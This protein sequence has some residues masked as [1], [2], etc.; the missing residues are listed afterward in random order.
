MARTLSELLLF[1][2]TRKPKIAELISNIR[3]LSEEDIDNIKVPLPWYKKALKEYKKSLGKRDEDA[4]VNARALEYISKYVV[5][6]VVPDGLGHLKEWRGENIYLVL[7]RNGNLE[8][9][10]GTALWFPDTGGVWIET[11][12][13]KFID[14]RIFGLPTISRMTKTEYT[15]YCWKKR[16][17]TISIS[18][19]TSSTNL[20]RETPLFRIY[21]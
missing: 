5:D 21:K 18:S 2:A 4:L 3:D 12:Y 20:V 16:N 7:D 1:E 8:I 14:P 19:G 9:K 11:V 15:E 13:S 17:A 6:G 10:T